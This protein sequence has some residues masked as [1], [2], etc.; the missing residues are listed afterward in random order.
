ME[1]IKNNFYKKH[2][3]KCKYCKS[4]FNYYHYEVYNFGHSYESI[5]CPCC[6]RNDLTF[7]DKIYYESIYRK[8]KRN[9][10]NIKES[11]KHYEKIC[12]FLGKYFENKEETKK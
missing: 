8:I 7:G 12:L 4:K 6:K 2:V 1:I 10:K 5:Q 11:K 9:F 3:H